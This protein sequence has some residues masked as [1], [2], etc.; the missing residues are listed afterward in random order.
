[1]FLRSALLG[2]RCRSPAPRRPDPSRFPWE[3][4]PVV[5]SARPLLLQLLR[6]LPP[7]CSWSRSSGGQTSWNGAHAGHRLAAHGH[8]LGEARANFPMCPLGEAGELVHL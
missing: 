4:A 1:M 8:L 6:R 2:L 7:L 3:L 5:T